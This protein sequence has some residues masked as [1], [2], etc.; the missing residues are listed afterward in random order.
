M[1]QNILNAPG[2][3]AD[4]DTLIAETQDEEQD[5]TW[6]KVDYTPVSV[7]SRKR[8]ANGDPIKDPVTQQDIFEVD[9]G[10][11]IVAKNAAGNYLVWKYDPDSGDQ[12]SKILDAAA[13]T[14][15]NKNL[16]LP[17]GPVKKKMKVASNSAAKSAP[18]APDELPTKAEMETSAAEWAEK[19]TQKLAAATGDFDRRHALMDGLEEAD[20]TFE[21]ELRNR[22]G[23]NPD[24]KMQD[25]ATE[26]LIEFFS[27]LSHQLISEKT[28]TPQEYALALKRMKHPSVGDFR[29]TI[30]YATIRLAGAAATTAAAALYLF[31]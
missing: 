17:A 3:D 19:I 31:S 21:A 13:L 14:P 12:K 23:G 24:K 6:E 16:A 11:E 9:T 28:I 26:L 8:D 10:W 20:Q 1:A 27:A 5:D 25:D 30:W 18:S 2:K 15:H 7:E 22:L 29:D 4:A